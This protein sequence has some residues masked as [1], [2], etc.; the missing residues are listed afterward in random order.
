MVSAY[1]RETGKVVRFSVGSRTNKT[2]NRVLVSLKLSEAKKIYTDKLKN[3]RYL[4]E[5]KVHSTK[6]YANNHLERMHLNYRTH[7]KRLNRRS[8]CYSRLLL[9]LIC[10]LKIYLWG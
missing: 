10:V 1:Q 7:L 9:M 4:I 8:I 5:K 6:Q 2:L 3:Y